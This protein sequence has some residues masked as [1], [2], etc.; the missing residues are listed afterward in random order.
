[1]EP[2]SEKLPTPAAGVV[3]M[4]YNDDDDD[5]DNDDDSVVEVA[6]AQIKFVMLYASKLRLFLFVL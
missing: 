6:I 1:M 3:P 5:D 4:V 2:L